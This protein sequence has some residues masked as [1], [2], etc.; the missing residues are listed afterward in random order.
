MN[1][2]A[3]L[4]EALD[5]TTSTNVRVEAMVDYFSRVQP[6]D[7]AWAV[8]FLCGRKPKRSISTKQLCE[9]AAELTKVPDWLFAECYDTVGDLAETIAL[10]LPAPASKSATGLAEW[11]EGQLLPM[12]SWTEA[13]RR[14][15]VEEAWSNWDA[16]ERLIANKLI[17]GGFR[18][19]VSQLLVVRALAQ[20]CRVPANTLAH[21]LM[22]EWTPTAEFFTRLISPESTVSEVSKP[23]PFFLAHPL[24]QEPQRLGDAHDW[25]AEW[26][27][28]GIRAQLI[29][30]QG[31][32]FLWSRGEE[33]VT[34]RYPEL[35]PLAEALPNGTVLDGELLPWKDGGVRPFADLQKRIGRKS[36]TRKLLVEIPVSFM[37]YDLLELASADFR[38][39]PLSKRRDRLEQ[40]LASHPHERLLLSPV[41]KFNSWEELREAR[42]TSRVRRVEGLMLKRRES[43]Y[44]VGRVRGDWWKWKIEPLTMDAVLT[45]AQRGHGKRASLYTDYT[46][47]VWD[48]EALVTI[49]K[50]Y[51]GLSDAEIRQVDS[52][53]R[54]NTLEKFGPVRLVKPHLVFELGFE[55]IQASSRHKSG[56][57]VRFPRILRP[58]PDK[59]A[60]E[61]DTLDQLR[62]LLIASSGRQA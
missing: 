29:R 15:A 2:F 18:V 53:V 20:F 19:G 61:A 6:R 42:I 48:G 39:E 59:T 38:G 22:G 32:T 31:G 13:K 23:Y 37:A 57:A 54:A 55:G 43:P 14:K 8:Y 30:R 35:M 5:R 12:K 58:R 50:A 46:F 41:V 3:R 56:I 21:R 7:A 27:W 17:T 11:I 60:A 34:D 24:D 45:A 4:F 10:L 25:L 40:L 26:K 16:T 51:S 62:R 28:D 49:A 52:F 47:S 36:L 1:E 9:W 44:R 33:L